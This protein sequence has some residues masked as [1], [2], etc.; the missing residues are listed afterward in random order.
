MTF[1]S[2]ARNFE[3]VLL[4]RALSRVGTGFYIDVGARHP[5]TN[6]VTRA[7]YDRGW[8][9]INVEP[10]SEAAR[11]LRAARP[12]D[13]TVQAALGSAP[14]LDPAEAGTAVETLAE[15]C[16]RHA[17]PEI[18]FLRVD[19]GGGERDVLAGA[20]FT[21]FRPWIVLVEATAS[22][23][24]TEA[25]PEWEAGLL[26]SGY[27]FAWFDG[28]NRF[29]VA[30]E[31][32]AG[33]LPHFRAPP[34]A[35]DDFLH[36]ADAEWA[37][38]LGDAATEAA[39]LRDRAEAA[40]F[41]ARV[42]E[43]R[44]ERAV[45]RLG[46]EAAL[47]ADAEARYAESRQELSRLHREVA[48]RHDKL[49]RQD[50]QL[51]RISE[52]EQETEA[53]RVWL[54]ATHASTSWRVTAPL[55]SA[56]ALAV[57]L[58]GGPNAPGPVAA[59]AKSPDDARASQLA[60]TSPNATRATPPIRA[61]HQFHAGS[62]TGDAITNAMLLT[63]GL[64]RG[65]GYRSEIYVEHLDP[66][67]ADELHPLDELPSH[68]GYVLLVRHSMGADSLP[69]ILAVPAPKVLIYHNITPPEHL[70]HLPMSQCYAR[71]GREQL[72]LL[73]ERVAAALA[74][75]EY[76]ALEL[77]ALGFDPVQACPLLF[78]VG[79]MERTPGAA[80]REGG[81]FTV[82]FVGRVL[83]A[84]GQADL[85]EAFARFRM[86]FTAPARLVLVGR[87]GGAG[88]RFH[89]DLLAAV[90]RHGIE[91]EVV[92]TGVV[93]D[94][95]RDAWYG[96]ADLYVSLSQHE[97]FGVPLVEAMT[98]GVPVLALPAGA[99]AETLGGGAELLEDA[100]PSAVAA[101]MVALAWDGAQR[102]A[103]GA[104]GRG[105]VERFALGRHVPRLVEAIVRAG[106]APPSDPAARDALAAGLRFAVAGH[107]NGTYSL[108]AINRA[109]ALAIEAER[110]G[111][112][113]VLPVEGEPTEELERVPAAERPAIAALAARPAPGTGPEVVV[114]QHY[115]LYVPRPGGDLPLALFFWE[116]SSVPADTV[117]TLNAAFRGVLAPSRF[118]A[119]ALVDSGVAAP[120]SVLGQAP[121]L[122]AFRA[123]AEAR[124]QRP[125]PPGPFAFLHVSS[126]FP[127]KGVDALLAAYGRAFRRGD[128]V[129]LIIKGFPNPHNDVAEQIARHRAEDR[130]FPDTR[131]VDEDLGEAALLDLYREADAMVLPT[132]GEGFNL[133]AAEAMAAGLPLIVTGFGGHMDFLGPEEARLV[134][135]DFARSGSH[136]ATAGSVWADPRVDD[137]A[138]ALREL[139]EVPTAAQERAARAE[140]RIAT[141]T[142]RAA[143]VERLAGTALD[144]LLAPPPPPLRVAWV[145]TWDVPCGIA[146]YSRHLLASLP[147]DGI[148]ELVVIADERS[149]RPSKERAAAPRAR[150]VWR[151]GSR[152]YAPGIAA[153]IAAGD[154]DAV[155]VQHQPGLFPWRK[156][157]RLLCHRALA[158]RVVVVVLHNTRHLLETGERERRATLRALAGASRVVVHTLADLNRLKSLGLVDNLV[159][160]P[161][162]TPESL[163]PRAQRALTPKGRGAAA[164]LIG[165]YGFFLP[166]KGLPQLVEALALLRR[167]WPGARLRLVNARYDARESED[168][169]A[170]CRAMAAQSGL[171][172]AVEFVT[173]F[174][175]HERSL[176]LLAECDVVVLP[177]QSSL[178]AAS[179]AVRIALAAGAPVAVTPLAVFD[180][181]AGAV[182][183][184]EGTDPE[185]I[186]RGLDELLA[187]RDRRA[188]VADAARR[189]L[190]DRRWETTG[191]RMAGMLRGLASARVAEPP[192]SPGAGPSPVSPGAG[193]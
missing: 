52:L 45:I 10:V 160:L 87:H 123:I 70:R 189:W 12:R 185:A 65:M 29:Y 46:R 21:Q 192:V 111:R 145:S 146:E 149:A 118:V 50:E 24:A 119:K 60:E 139:V 77:R 180:E 94:A 115:P 69:R 3:D 34:N 156:L 150:P 38:R 17:P 33:L 27:R 173:N 157:A 136:V 184:L 11:R 19:L 1:I 112:V 170:L 67:L 151:L 102:K 97:G 174:L 90:R 107:V 137:L 62:A 114:S 78:D 110:P 89:G 80:A 168:E 15:I 59:L 141:E 31:R 144:L 79:A 4:W 44:T 32:A 143:L 13:V 2:Y 134:D 36:A 49:E 95:E 147:L 155:V 131:L 14:G 175:Q 75:S 132:R 51:Q 5:D 159:L 88:D 121:P 74:D 68:A 58:R 53:T 122:E 190:L 64:L 116:E 148:A 177:Y 163:P 93:S 100:A 193:P 127:R 43:E 20:D 16:R 7:F 117:A 152:A 39:I 9:G 129:R 135:F 167:R 130:D 37:R 120:V 140:V 191:Q 113:R 86:E 125:R 22:G 55:R 166:N 18:H 6:S 85:I 25:A 169:I 106:A 154:A 73:R 183:C 165:C 72:P 42:Y 176:E 158:R 48:W 138:L 171:Q 96:A 40:E 181:A 83:E 56:A 108:A 23:A 133:P 98:R 178:E 76:N 172:D 124:R 82:L 162:G 61:V 109:L 91:G 57:R 179:G 47:T 81:P 66:A 35:R 30:A 182:A 84:K 105:A 54:R 187:D 104:R 153:A 26:A 92:F 126:C 186:A 63:R 164:P 28:L 8:S 71:L 161:H 101:R 128:A 103:L 41:R 99:V 142:S 188:A